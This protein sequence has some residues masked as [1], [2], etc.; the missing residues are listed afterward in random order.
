MEILENENNSLKSND[1]ICV[2]CQD[3]LDTNDD[4][5]PIITLRCQHQFHTQCV[6]ECAWRGKVAC[7][8]C[9][10]IPI[11]NHNQEQQEENLDYDYHYHNTQQ[12]QK[13]FLKG[14]RMFKNR[15]C[16]NNIKVT[17]RKY[18]RAKEQEKKNK[19]E[20]QE[21]LQIHKKMKQEILQEVNLI[22]DKYLEHHKKKLI[23]NLMISFYS[24]KSYYYLRPNFKRL[25]K[26][27]AIATG[28]VPLEM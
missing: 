14:L 16:P 3:S 25:K 22:K 26:N 6:L 19:K 10:S 21:M 9:R 28:Y 1:N 2:I 12:L 13:F 15:S 18:Y 7:S 23:N 4:F 8:I 11:T 20:I 5:N 24:R 17:V 27:I